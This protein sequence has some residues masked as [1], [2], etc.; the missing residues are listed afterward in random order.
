MI[1][2]LPFLIIYNLMLY[3]L[4]ERIYIIRYKLYNKKQVYM[5]SD[6]ITY[7]IGMIEYKRSKLFKIKTQLFLLVLILVLLIVGV[8]LI[9]NS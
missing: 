4:A 2:I 6:L 5:N 3:L 1:F 9:N 8:F 7:G